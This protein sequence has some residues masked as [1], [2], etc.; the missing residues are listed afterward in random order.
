MNFFYHLKQILL[1]KSRSADIKKIDLL[2]SKLSEKITKNNL[3]ENEIRKHKI[4][5]FYQKIKQL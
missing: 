5:L 4:F 2:E 1:F 3:L